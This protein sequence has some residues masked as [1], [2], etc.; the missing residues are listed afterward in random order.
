MSPI[1][2]FLIQLAMPIIIS[3][4]TANYLRA[5]L[6]PLLCD[7]CGTEDRAR[8]WSRC[9]T[10]VMLL[11]PFMLV[12]VSGISKEISLRLTLACTMGGILAVVGVTAFVVGK[13]MPARDHD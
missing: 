2:F 11:V 9:F 1:I 4:C 10:V 12:L 6:Q 7:L 5:A 13:Y 3:L 8:L